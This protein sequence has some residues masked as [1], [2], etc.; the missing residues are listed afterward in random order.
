MKAVFPSLLGLLAPGCGG[1]GLERTVDPEVESLRVE[2]IEPDWG[3]TCGGNEVTITGAGF[4]GDVTVKFGNAALDVTVLDHGELVVTAPDAGGVE[5]GVDVT[6]ESDLGAVV[7][8]G[9]YTFTDGGPPDTGP[10]EGVGGLIE[11]SHLQ[12]ACPACFSVTEGVEVS[13]VAAFHQ[14][15]SGT[16]T[17]WMPATGTCVTNPTSTAPTS[18]FEDVGSTVHLT[19]GSTTMSLA[20]VLDGGQTRY[21]ALNLTDSQFLRNAAW[22]LTVADGGEWGPF[23]VDD[24]VFTGSM[25]TELTP[26]DILQTQPRNAFADVINRAGTTFTWGPYGGT[27]TFIVH[28]VIYNA[29][30][31][32]VLGQVMCRGDDN[33]SLTVPGTYLTYPQGSLVAVYMYRH[34]AGFAAVDAMGAFIES[35]VTI[36]VL[37]T[38]SLR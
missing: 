29:Q 31:T 38:A 30:G 13:A 9:G 21:E 16:W 37:G 18:A 14:P 10:S 34:Q 27:G 17:G 3:P 24:A 5:L 1:V 15:V 32:T 2:A 7:V 35:S 20:R 4:V 8:E 25:I 19:S 6:V 36:G 26:L 11:L 12:I 28:L 22:D 33:G 23:S